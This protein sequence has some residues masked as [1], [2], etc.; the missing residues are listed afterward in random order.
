MMC[1]TFKGIAA[2]ITDEDAMALLADNSDT[3]YEDKPDIDREY[4]AI[5]TLLRTRVP[6][7]YYC[8][9]C[10]ALHPVSSLRER[11]QHRLETL[12][13]CERELHPYILDRIDMD[14]VAASNLLSVPSEKARN[15]LDALLVVIRNEQHG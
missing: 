5:G 6:T 2:V 7:H 13:P 8:H 1:M 10:S 15:M 11:M 9:D 4:G 14:I 12:C 3:F